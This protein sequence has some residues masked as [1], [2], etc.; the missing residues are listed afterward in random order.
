MLVITRV[1][2]RSI[3]NV[4]TDVAYVSPYKRVDSKEASLK[5]AAVPAIV[6]YAQL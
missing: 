1:V 5:I 3:R 6:H 2:L 4:L